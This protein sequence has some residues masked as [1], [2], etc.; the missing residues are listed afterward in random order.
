MRIRFAMPVI[1]L[2]VATFA[3]CVSA[4]PPAATSSTKMP[5]DV[6][7]SYMEKQS[8]QILCTESKYR[9]CLSVSQQRCESEVSAV[10][11]KCT[12]Q[13]MK[14]MP[15]YVASSEHGRRYGEE[16]GKCLVMRQ[17]M[18]GKYNLKEIQKCK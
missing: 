1:F 16:Y 18:N 9:S 5:K 13:M 11:P 6:F 8:P 4:P 7:L 17:I 14:T 2:L 10:A 12:A 3:A 15:E